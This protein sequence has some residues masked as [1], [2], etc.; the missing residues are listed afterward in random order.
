MAR[1]NHSYSCWYMGVLARESSAMGGKKLEEIRFIAGLKF[2]KGE[3]PYRITQKWI[4][5]QAT[6]SPIL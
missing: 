1:R 4:L 5:R 6:P 2:K 3:W